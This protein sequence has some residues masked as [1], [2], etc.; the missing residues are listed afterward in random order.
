[1]HKTSFDPI[2][3]PTILEHDHRHLT[4]IIRDLDEIRSQHRCLTLFFQVLNKYKIENCITTLQDGLERFQV[5]LR[6]IGRY[7]VNSVLKISRELHKAE[8][9]HDIQT[10]LEDIYGITKQ[11]ATKLDV[12][13]I[14]VDKI[15]SEVHQMNEMMK[16]QQVHSAPSS[17]GTNAFET[18]QLLRTS[19]ACCGDCSAPD[20]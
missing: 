11:M 1:V 15:E 3:G 18:A 13:E 10:R 16:N 20:K 19:Q 2:F 7:P 12:V 14:K 4:E 9:L 5:S 8:V 17:V 6:V